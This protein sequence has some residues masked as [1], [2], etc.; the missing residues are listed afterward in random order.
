MYLCLCNAVTD[1]DLAEAIAE[2]CTTLADLNR[3]TGCGGQCG[4]C[5]PAIGEFLERHSNPAV[6]EPATPSWPAAAPGA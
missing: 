3:A 5:L 2:G 4:R 6:A 1:R